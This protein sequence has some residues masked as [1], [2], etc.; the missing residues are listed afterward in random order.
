MHGVL[1][2]HGEV[3]WADRESD[4]KVVR[5][6]L[7]CS[8]CQF[9]WHV[10]PGSGRKRGWCMNCNGPTCGKLRCERTCIHWKKKHELIAS[11]HATKAILVNDPTDLGL[12]VSVSVP[13]LEAIDKAA[14][15]H[16]CEAG[17][18]HLGKA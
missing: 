13:S 9:T 3:E 10:V 17:I 5:D 7:Q 15:I 4:R 2:P 1:H 16:R 14:S 18:I 8:H 12:P 6:C 11:G